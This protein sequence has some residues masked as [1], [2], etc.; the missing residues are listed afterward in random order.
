[1]DT[2]IPDHVLKHISRDGILES[3]HIF[4]N[5]VKSAAKF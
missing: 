1:M 4:Y 2:S 3:F 5:Y